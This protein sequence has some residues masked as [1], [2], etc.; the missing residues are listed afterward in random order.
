LNT[1]A[2]PT[3]PSIVFRTQVFIDGEFQNAADGETFTTVNPAN[4]QV[5]AEVAAGD[6]A[7]VDRAVRAA[8][9]AFKDG[10]WA[11]LA[12]AAR[13]V[14]LQRFADVIVEHAEELALLDCL[15]AGKPIVDCREIDVPEL[16]NTLRWYAEAIDKVFDSIAPTAR[17]FLGLIV[18]EP[19]GVVG[20][21]LPWNFPAMILGLKMAPALASG[22]SMVVK[23]AEQTSLSALRIAELAIQAGIPE[24]VLNVVPGMGKTAGQA[25]GRHMDVDVVSFTGSTEIG[26]EFLRYSS[27]SNLK[28]I[29]LEC[30]G[31]SPQIIMADAGDLDVV[32]EEVLMAGFW[33]MGE[34]CSCGSRLIVHRSIKDELLDR[35]ARRSAQ[36]V[37]GDPQDPATKIGPMIEPRHLEKVMDYVATG[38]EEGADVILGGSRTLIETGGYFVSPTIFDNVRN[39]MKIARDEIFGPVISTITFSTEAEAIE[40]ANDTSYGLAA[41]LW[42]KDVDTALRLSRSIEAGTVSVNCYSEGDITTPFGGFKQSGFG[43]RDM[44]LEA[45]DQYTETKVIWIQTR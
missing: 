19:L 36:W 27:E 39:D 44:G 21:V 28:R 29:I 7:D 5:L 15:E 34:N 31:K 16:A 38:R 18:K 20:T 25:L 10:R 6:I 37:V 8:R 12:P 30:G 26:R 23:P 42:T 24:G 22:A 43:G 33:N 14:T 11:G 41:S 9:A 45:F 32:A 3:D 13:K 2:E 1:A 35:L 40:I 4:G 17:Q